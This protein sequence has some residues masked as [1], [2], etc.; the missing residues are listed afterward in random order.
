VHKY[1]KNIGTMVIS[2]YLLITAVYAPFALYKFVQ[3]E[4]YIINKEIQVISLQAKLQE[5]AATPDRVIISCAN[6]QKDYLKAIHNAEVKYNIPKGLLTQVAYVESNFDPKAV[7]HKGAVGIMQ[8]VPRWHPEVNARDPYASI[9]Y[10]G[11]HLTDLKERFGNWEMAL[12]AWNWGPG[13]L[14]K[15]T[16]SKAPRET[17]NFI[18]KVLKVVEA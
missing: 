15:H 9:D 3:M 10:A 14:V 12:A 1:L 6:N 16:I 17:R 13:N 5:R 7:S 11:E 4:D 18:K 8:I 2:F